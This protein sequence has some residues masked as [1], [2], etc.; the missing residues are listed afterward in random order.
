MKTNITTLDNSLAK[1]LLIPITEA[2]ITRTSFQ[3]LVSQFGL[4]K[5][6]GFMPTPLLS[7]DATSFMSSLQATD[8][9]LPAV[10]FLEIIIGQCY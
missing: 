10:G 3:D 1:E 7:E 8:Y 6:F 5:F 9:V 4:N 2:D